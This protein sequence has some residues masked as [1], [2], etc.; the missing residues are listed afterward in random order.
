MVQS[1]GTAATAATSRLTVAPNAATV[2]DDLLVIVV[3]V[4]RAAPVAT[5]TSVTDTAANSWTRAGVVRQGT[6]D[7]EMWYA[8]NAAP[9]LT[10]GS[11]NVTTTAVSSIA[12]TVM[13]LSGIATSAPLDV[14][15]SRSGGTQTPSIGP[16]AVTHQPNEIAVA[17]IG[18]ATPATPT[19]QTT[20]YNVLAA[21]QSRVSGE[22]VGEQAAFRALTTSGG[23]QYGATLPSK[24]P[25]TGIIATFEANLAP[26]T[27]TPTPTVTPSPP[28][29][30]PIKHVVVIYQE[31]H[32]FDNVLGPWC[33][34]TGMCNGIPAAVT[35]KSGVVV[36]PSDATDRI[37]T[38][39]HSVAGNAAAVDGGKMDGWASLKGCSAPQY[40]CVSAF[41]PS[42]IPNLIALARNFA[43][44]DATFSMSDSASW[45]GHLY[46]VA[47]TTDGFTGDIP[48][49]KNGVTPG[50]GWGCDSDLMGRW[51]AT[52]G[53]AYSMQPS[54]IPDYSLNSTQYPNGGS[55]APTSVAHVPTI[56]DELD[57]AGLPWRFYTSNYDWATC[58]SFA[59]C[60]Y[61]SQRN[62]MVPTT[63]ILND[64]GAGTLPSF[65]LLLPSASTT[66]S[67]SQHNDTSMLAGD[68]WLGQ[69]LTA[70]EDGPEWATTTVFITYDD[71]GCFY[72]HVAPGV[73]PDGTQQGSRSP[74]VII[75]P[76]AVAGY[77]DH[78]HTSFAGILAYVEQ[79]FGLSPLG[80]NDAG[81]YPFT[82]SFNYDQA[83]LA[84]VPMT[85][86]PLPP[87]SRDLA[88]PEDPSD[89]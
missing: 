39:E 78:T 49:P 64:A 59:G 56:M 12:M 5:I 15:A 51:Q 80:M 48:S 71:C 35:L 81:A 72:D 89:T 86:T 83:P 29:G 24:L 13:E 62:N 45:G 85:V 88:E 77:V 11:V 38:M 30:S 23:Q 18:W 3:E 50:Q 61:T 46:A 53:G 69:V 57:A 21:A 25:W 55:F 74:L 70:I 73:N 52:L 60:L 4:R 37:P 6:T 19:G 1:F 40:A 7:E 79:T 82:N 10:S 8:V 26:P 36:T 41:Q 68:N 16:T 84:G 65:S 47:A 17:A 67:T 76:Y 54:C 66:S 44:S 22:A 42:Q 20:G 31:N 75:S 58:P 43:I 32:S 28:P 34:Q 27:P 9:I 63:S 87:P 14:I 33:D 2:V